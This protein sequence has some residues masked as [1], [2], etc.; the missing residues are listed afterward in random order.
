MAGIE[1]NEVSETERR[2]ESEFFRLHPAAATDLLESLDTA[3]QVAILERQP[4]AAMLPVWERVSPDIGRRLLAE[5]S[6]PV[7]RR[8]CEA[9]TRAGSRGCSPR[10]T[11]TNAKSCW[12]SWATGPPERSARS[13]NTRRTAPER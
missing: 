7:R 8:R 10:S 3:E 11:T 12:R 13:C 9:S 2:L 4:V 5:L 1:E 6:P